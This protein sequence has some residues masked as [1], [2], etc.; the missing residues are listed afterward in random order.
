EMGDSKGEQ[1][2]AQD[3][4]SPPRELVLARDVGSLSLVPCGL[5]I[6][7]QDRL[8]LTGGS[9]MTAA[10]GAEILA[11]Q[12]KDVKVSYPPI[13]A[14]WTWRERRHFH[15]M[16]YP[17][18]LQ[19]DGR[20]LRR[21]ER[22]HIRPDLRLEPPHERDIGRVGVQRLERAVPLHPLDVGAMSKR[23]VG[24]HQLEPRHGRVPPADADISTGQVVAGEGIERIEPAPALGP[25]PA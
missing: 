15:N 12:P 20:S 22:R 17:Y 4:A 19:R 2:P 9:P 5:G 16:K 3:K 13:R 10:F 1:E 7:H 21:R 25:D 24:E 18:R 23:R 11:R 6:A 8:P 14:A